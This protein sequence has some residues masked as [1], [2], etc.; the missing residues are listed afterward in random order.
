MAEV[1]AWLDA[2]EAA[3]VAGNEAWAK[4]DYSVEIPQRGFRC[5]R[6]ETKRRWREDGA[7]IDVP[8]NMVVHLTCRPFR[9]TVPLGLRSAASQCIRTIKVC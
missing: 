1:E 2:E 3:H 5:N 8:P 7:P 4:G 9:A 6:D